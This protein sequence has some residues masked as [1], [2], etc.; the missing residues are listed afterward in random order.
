VKQFAERL[1][2]SPGVQDFLGIDANE[3]FLNKPLTVDMYDCDGW[4]WSDNPYRW[5]PDESKNLL[6]EAKGSGFTVPYWMLRYCGYFTEG[7]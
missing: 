6:F 2:L 5:R 1:G 7:L 3:E 4:I